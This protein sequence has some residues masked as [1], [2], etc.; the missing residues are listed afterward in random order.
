MFNTHTEERVADFQLVC[1]LGHWSPVEFA[2]L[3]LRYRF[4]GGS[5]EAASKHLQ[6][7]PGLP[8]ITTSHRGASR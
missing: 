3:I 5:Y 1:D 4:K 8:D 2:F 7:Y 6:A